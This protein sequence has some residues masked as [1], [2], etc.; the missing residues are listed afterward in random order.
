MIK[1]ID[2]IKQDNPETDR[3]PGAVDWSVLDALKV[4][5][6]PGKPDVCRT[7]MTIYL[8]SLPA[9]MESIKAAA[10][11]LDVKTLMDAA[12]SMKSS[13]M[14]IGAVVFGKTCAELEQLGRSNNLEKVPALL[15]RAEIEFAAACSA[16]RDALETEG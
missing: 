14:S 2:D 10:K 7:L 6:K 4:L 12:H 9:Q 15:I 3:Q 13:S 5:Q 1:P 8:N 11:E 16:F